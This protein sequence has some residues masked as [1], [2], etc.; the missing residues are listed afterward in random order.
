MRHTLKSSSLPSN[1]AI[2]NYLEP[3]C[4]LPRNHIV[5]H[6]YYDLISIP[7]KISTMKKQKFVGKEEIVPPL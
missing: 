1:G 2:I 7:L 4:F 6:H 3:I 5:S